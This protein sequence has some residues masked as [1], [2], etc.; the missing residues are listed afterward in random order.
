[1]FTLGQCPRCEKKCPPS[2]PECPPP[3]YPNS[4]PEH[5]LPVGCRVGVFEVVM[6]FMSTCA[7]RCQCCCPARRPGHLQ[8]LASAPES[9]EEG[10][11]PGGASSAFC[12]FGRKELPED[13]DAVCL[14]YHDPRGRCPAS[15]RTLRKCSHCENL[16]N[17]Q[18]SAGCTRSLSTKTQWT[19]PS[20]AQRSS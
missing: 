9:R 14:A 17:W 18:T 7:G 15:F 19:S 5:R 1:M 13:W 4:V 11:V 8:A 12:F 10:G 20:T 6:K 16:C 2:P 3:R